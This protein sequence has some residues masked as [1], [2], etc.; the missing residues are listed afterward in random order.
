M[1]LR[2]RWVFMFSCEPQE[3]RHSRAKHLPVQALFENRGFACLIF[4]GPIRSCLIRSSNGG[5]AG[6]LGAKGRGP[7]RVVQKGV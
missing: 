4:A 2:G 6:R 3:A 5:D 7:F 1:K